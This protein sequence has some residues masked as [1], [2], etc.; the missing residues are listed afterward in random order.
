[1]TYEIRRTSQFKRHLNTLTKRL[2]LS[3]SEARETVIEIQEATKILAE[4]GTLP[5]EH[6]YMLHE[7]EH[8]PWLNF[9]EFHVSNDV[10]V[11]YFDRN[12]KNVIRMVGIY[13]HELLSTGKLD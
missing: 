13:N 3:K 4:T 9:M 10:L 8:E 2:K 5:A 12:K 6:G 1:M 11:V 7:L